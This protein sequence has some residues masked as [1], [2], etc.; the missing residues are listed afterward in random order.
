MPSDHPAEADPYL[1]ANVFGRSNSSL[2]GKWRYLVDPYE[3]GYRDIFGNA[4]SSGYFRNRRAQDPG[5]LIEYCFDTADQLD[6]PGDWNSQRREL[7]LYEGSIWY[8]REFQWEPH[9]GHR[10]FLCFGAANYE[11]QVWVNGE[12]AGEHEG[13][14]TPFHLEVTPLLQRGSNFVVCKVDNRR[15]AEAVPG[16]Q[17]DWWNYGGLTRDVTLVDLPATFIR[18]YGIWLDHSG[19]DRIRGWVRIDGPN[20]S[21]RIKVGIPEAGLEC[22]VHTND[23]GIAEFELEPK[24]DRWSPQHPRLYDVEIESESDRVTEPIG[25]R[26]IEVRDEDILLNGEPIFLCGI[27]LHEE[28]PTREGRAHSEEDARIALGWARELGCNFV[29][30]AH[31]PHNEHQVRM[32]DRMGLLLWCEIP[33]YW[34]IGWTNPDTLATAR[35]QLQEMIARDRNRASV[36]IWSVA[37]ETLPQPERLTFLQSLIETARSDDP[38][39]LVSAAIFPGFQE[40]GLLGEFV[41]ARARGESA[42]APVVEINDPLGELL[43]VIGRND[44]TSWYMPGL[45]A[46]QT[47]LD[48][49]T[50][51]RIILE[52]VETFEWKSRFRKPLIISE[53]GAGALQGLHGDELDV[54]TE[55]LQAKIYRSQIEALD[56]ISFLRG[57]SPWILQDFRSPRRALP[58]IQDFFNRKGLISDRGVKKAAFSV[59]REFYRRLEGAS[60]S[61]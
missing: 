55:E 13:G 6:V 18:D 32:A 60:S 35:K 54:F 38:T 56:R 37:N 51:R 12:P 17:S 20:L 53:F 50:V 48:E 5:E 41:S 52:T 1:I 4:V 16:L 27:S 42:P 10:T 23:R 36:I 59:L 49:R 14:F 31:Y 39:R 8:Q 45:V 61:V 43:D 26:T 57:F 22:D 21:Q 24:V 9:S 46:R 25:F 33:V 44:Y 11:A 47:N 2:S 7:F 3:A 29:R 28:A 19:G 15:R 30:L 58:D 34:K 40:I